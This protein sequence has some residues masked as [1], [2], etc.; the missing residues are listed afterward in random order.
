MARAAVVAVSVIRVSSS[1]Y[2][3]GQGTQWWCRERLQWGHRRATP[4]KLYLLL[5][6]GGRALLLQLLA[7]TLLLLV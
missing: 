2:S 7:L 3:S 6:Q 4:H 5:R 1:S